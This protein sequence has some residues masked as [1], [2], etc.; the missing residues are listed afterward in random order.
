MK[1]QI[2]ILS[3]P[4]RRE[5]LRQLTEY[6]EPQ[7]SAL[8]LRRCESVEIITSQFD[9]KYDLGTNRQRL[10]EQSDAE[11][12]NFC[13]DDD[14][15]APDYIQKILPLLDGVDQIG[16]QVECHRA[17]RKEPLLADHSLKYRNWHENRNGRI[18]VPGV[19]CRDISHMTPMRRELSMRARMEGGVGEDCRWANQ[20]RD[21]G[22][23]RTEHYVAE[24]MYFYLE[25]GIKNDARDPFDPWR[26]EFIE[27]LKAKSNPVLS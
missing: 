2:L 20:I 8:G 10:K 5:F 9:S 11:Y 24:V 18:G 1:W 17:G 23:V 12:I 13:D 16:F 15:L 19:L 4:A 7:I 21:L 22:I 14:L 26:L 3:Q 6:L 27:R 25:R